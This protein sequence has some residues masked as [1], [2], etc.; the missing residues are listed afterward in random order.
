[1][2]YNTHKGSENML[3]Y[4]NNSI[5]KLFGIFFALYNLL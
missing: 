2:I 3:Y 5:K 4:A 1:M